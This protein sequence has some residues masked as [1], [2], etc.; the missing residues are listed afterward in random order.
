M[1]SKLIVTAAMNRYLKGPSAS[2]TNSQW[3]TLVTVT[4]SMSL[5]MIIQSGEGSTSSSKSMTGLLIG[6]I[7]TVLKVVVSCYTGSKADMTLKKYESLP[8]P[9]QLSQ[10]MSTWGVCCFILCAIAEPSKVLSFSSFFGGWNWATWLVTISFMI[11]TSISQSLLKVLD[12]LM[13]NIGEAVAV[14]VIYA[15]MVFMP[16]FDTKFE[17]M[18]FLAM[19]VV[20]MAVITYIVLKQD[21]TNAKKA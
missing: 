12:S 3:A 21:L 4:L 18:T 17:T 14:L 9:A 16:M 20:V 6:V 5:F 7:M 19:L 11:K 15:C 10:L 8:L 1:G 2:Q 13:K